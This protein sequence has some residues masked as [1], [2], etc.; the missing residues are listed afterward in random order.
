MRSVAVERS[1]SRGHVSLRRLRRPPFGI[2]FPLAVY[3][4]TRLVSA[5]FIL[6]AAR[7]QIELS[8]LVEGY[9]V[10]S[11][12][13]AAPDYASVTSNWDGQWYLSIASHGYP[14]TIP[15]DGAGHVVQNEWGF[16]PAYPLLVGAI[17]RITGLGF[18]VVAPIL[19]LLLG[20]AAVAVMFRLVN[21]CAGRFAACAT[22]LLTCTY[23]AAPSMQIAYSESLALLLLCTALLLLRNRHYSWLLPVL[24]TLSLTRGVALA[25]VPVLIVHG[26]SRYRRRSK[27]PFPVPDRWRVTGLAGL[28]IATTALWPAIAAVTTQNSEAYTVTISSWSGTTGKLRVLTEFP[29]LAWSQGGILGLAVLMFVIALTAGIVLRRDAS[30]WGP[31]VRAWAG[32]YPLYLLL[33]TTPGSNNIRHLLLAFPLM[34]PFP[35][36]V[37]SKSDRFRR[38][39]FVAVLASCGLAT[40]WLWISN[41]LVVSSPPDGSGFP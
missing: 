41:Y 33:A 34:W 25:F 30:V 22:V 20:A 9:H 39:G 11:P 21:Q 10:T 32:F 1:V 5:L 40:Q 4:A 12:S 17:M 26:I 8:G 7:S 2:W 36:E 23:M 38:A 3:A 29:A 28:A 16:Y 6:I 24:V 14:T 27:D 37:V 18:L 19:S 35:E 13:A 31:E 15:R